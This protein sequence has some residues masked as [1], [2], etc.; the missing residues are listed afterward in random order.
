MTFK[1]GVGYSRNLMLHCCLSPLASYPSPRACEM[2]HN[3]VRFHR[4]VLPARR[5]TPKVKD[6]PLSTV[7]NFLNSLKFS[8]V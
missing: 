3:I 7:R 8:V 4:K 5:P 6:Y 2:F 1:H